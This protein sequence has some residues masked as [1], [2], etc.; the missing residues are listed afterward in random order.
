[1]RGR[2]VVEGGG[3]LSS[4]FIWGAQL[5]LGIH[6]LGLRGV[7]MWW[8]FNRWFFNLLLI[9]DIRADRS[10]YLLEPGTIMLSLFWHICQEN[11]R[12]SR[13]RYWYP[14][15]QGYVLKFPCMN[16]MNYLIN[17]PTVCGIK[18]PVHQSHCQDFY[19]G[20]SSILF[21]NP[22]GAWPKLVTPHNA[23]RLFERK[24]PRIF[25]F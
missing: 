15:K 6:L 10:E 24:P 7:L 11:F 5:L 1:M 19:P 3:V 13:S 23:R 16:I 17:C 4:Y 22:C 25:N 9:I 18:S 2:G 21:L 8:A 12:S 20:D 14:C